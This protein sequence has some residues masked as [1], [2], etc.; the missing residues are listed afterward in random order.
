MSDVRVEQDSVIR[1]LT[2][3]RQSLFSHESVGNPKTIESNLEQT[4]GWYA[5]GQAVSGWM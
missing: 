5:Q 3:I 4:M 2:S 1:M